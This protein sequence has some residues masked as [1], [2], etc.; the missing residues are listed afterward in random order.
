MTSA[1]R[2]DFYAGSY[3][4]IDGNKDLSDALGL[5]KL[6]CK[7]GKSVSGEILEVAI[8]TGLQSEYTDLSSPRIKS[9]TGIDS[10][11]GMLSNA[12][13]RDSIR[14]NEKKV[15]LMQMDAS[16]MK[17]LPS[18]SFDTVIDTFSFCVF[19]DPESVLKEM[20]R[21]VKNRDAGGRIILLENSVSTNPFLKGI[22]DFT[23]PIITPMSRWCRWNVNVPQLAKEANLRADNIEEIQSGTILYGQYSKD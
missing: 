12:A 19:D 9:Y 18:D 13:L 10:S 14:S 7:L 6:R 17:G 4:K 21:V 2:Y 8:G 20:K 11:N 5:N 16:T 3:D 1:S 15:K 22:Q 23:E